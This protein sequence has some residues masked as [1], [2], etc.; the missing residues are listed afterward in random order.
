MSGDDVGI[1]WSTS[2]FADGLWAKCGHGDSSV[3][4]FPRVGYP[5]HMSEHV[6][7][8][9]VCV[10][11]G[12]RDCAFQL[13]GSLASVGSRL[14]DWCGDVMDRDWILRAL[15]T[16]PDILESIKVMGRPVVEI[17]IEGTD[18]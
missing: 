18:A 16:V 11:D 15:D 5:G 6:I 3:S 4:V 10:V 1:R 13:S 8:S 14:M 12:E 9:G 7:L 2:V 17:T